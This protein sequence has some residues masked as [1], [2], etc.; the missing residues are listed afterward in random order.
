MIRKISWQNT[1][2]PA[3]NIVFV[4]V[5]QITYIPLYFPILQKR[6]ERDMNWH[7]DRVTSL[8]CSGTAVHWLHYTYD[9]E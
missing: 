3:V 2:I 4:W 7:R 5:I 6:Y 8:T 1:K 9:Y